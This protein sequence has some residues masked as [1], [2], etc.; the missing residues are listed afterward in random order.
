[1]PEEEKSTETYNVQF[2]HCSRGSPGPNL[3]NSLKPE[4]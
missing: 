4:S 1:M 3:Q 2:C